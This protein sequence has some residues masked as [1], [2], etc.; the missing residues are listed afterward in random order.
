M[1]GRPSEMPGS[2]G[3]VGVSGDQRHGFATV[4]GG[5][6][7]VLPPA[8]PGPYS[9]ASAAR[10]SRARQGTSS[11]EVRD[12]LNLPADTCY[13]KTIDPQWPRGRGDGPAFPGPGHARQAAARAPSPA[14]SRAPATVPP[15]RAATPHLPGAP[16]GGRV[17]RVDFLAQRPRLRRRDGA[18]ARPPLA[19][20]L[21]D[22]ARRLLRA[23]HRPGGGPAAGRGL[24]GALAA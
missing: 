4:N 10:I 2:S 12:P 6:P 19:H 7:A 9:S 1:R 18:A 13:N 15:C 17:Q 5:S 8:P 21:R 14:G 24:T 16:R 3:V 23:A 20:G 11:V 22:V